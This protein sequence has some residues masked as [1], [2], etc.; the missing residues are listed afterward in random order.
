MNHLTFL[1]FVVT[2]QVGEGG[3]GEEGV[4][5][6]RAAAEGQAKKAAQEAAVMEVKHP[7]RYLKILN[8]P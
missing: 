4:A 5:E 1:F 3:G 6:V 8:N 2:V 7:Q